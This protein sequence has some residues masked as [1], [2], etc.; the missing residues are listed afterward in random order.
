M[1]INTGAIKHLIFIAGTRAFQGK[2]FSLLT[3]RTVLDTGK[4]IVGMI[5]MS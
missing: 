4:N 2:R 3:L 1:H 5:A